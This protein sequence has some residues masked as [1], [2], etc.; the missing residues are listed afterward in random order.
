MWPLRLSVFCLL[1]MLLVVHPGLGALTFLAAIAATAAFVP[2]ER[3]VER[4]LFPLPVYVPAR[5]SVGRHL[6]LVHHS[7]EGTT[8]GA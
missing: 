4:R 7:D 2:F 6:H 3:A 1:P 5:T 8:H